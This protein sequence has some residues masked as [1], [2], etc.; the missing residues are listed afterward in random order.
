MLFCPILFRSM[1]EKQK[2]AR[3]ARRAENRAE[4]AARET[5]AAKEEARLVE[6]QKQRELDDL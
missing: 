2:W 1:I 4:L 6:K 3:R 5:L